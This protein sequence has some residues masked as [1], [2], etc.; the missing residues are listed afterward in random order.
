MLM[1]ENKVPDCYYLT[2]I[3]FV[4]EKVKQ[5]ESVINSKKQYVHSKINMLADQ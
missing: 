5:F 4:K 2:K 1:N 3:E